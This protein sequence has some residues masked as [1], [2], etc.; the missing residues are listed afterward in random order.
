M[1]PPTMCEPEPER[2]K[3]LPEAVPLTWFRRVGPHDERARELPACL[4]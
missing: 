1:P 3:L 2:L 4:R